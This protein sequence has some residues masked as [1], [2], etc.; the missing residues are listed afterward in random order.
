MVLWRLLRV[1]WANVLRN[2]R[3]FLF[4]SVGLV[5]G[6]GTFTFFV[7]LGAGIKD[8]VLN[9]IYP[10]N[11][12]EVEPA[13]VGLLGLREE[14]VDTA[15]FGPGTVRTFEAL[16][17]V[18]AVYPKLRS[19]LQAR[20]WGGRSIF[21]YDARTEAFFDGLDPALVTSELQAVERV[22]AKRERS[23]MRRP[24]PCLRDDECPLG[25][26]CGPSGA[27]RRVEYWRRFAAPDMAV[28]CAREGDGR[29]CLAGETCLGGLCR[30]PCEGGCPTGE[31]CA[32]VP[33]CA[34]DGCR[35]CAPVCAADGDC[36]STRSCVTGS[37]G[38]RSCQRLA[39]TLERPEAQFSH[40]SRDGRGRVLGR[41]AN[42]VP[43]GD[44]ACEP[45]SCPPGTYCAPHSIK[46][47]EG[48]CERPLPVVLSPFLIEV[49]NTAV[50][51]SLGLQPID[52]TDALL[53]VQF[54]IQLGNSFFADDLPEDQQIVR[55]TEITGFS[56]KALDFGATFPLDVVRR[57]NA[58]YKGTAAAERYDTFIIETAGNE[59]VS[60]L[61]ADL[62]GRGFALSRKSQDARKAADVLFILTVVFS[63]ISLVIM[64]VAAV[65]ITHTFLMIVTERRHEIGIMRAVGASRA[66]I[67]RIVLAEAALL[68][69]FGGA[70]GEL[71]GFAAS[72]GVNLAAR[73]FLGQV[74]FKPDDFFVYEASTLASG[75]LFALVFCL[76]GASIPARRAARL[77][78][79]VVLTS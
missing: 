42:G 44:P 39:C 9:R 54:R 6:V 43:P 12:I 53:G 32:A 60:A 15:S 14:V 11:Q 78:P 25:Q 19:K 62:E 64:A 55:R 40:R 79:A 13:T 68:G 16:G 31:I 4:S 41:C 2:K 75:V 67:R 1:V 3:S 58:R 45:S 57:I 37:D 52:G 8:G 29:R 5:V 73:A 7:A 70:V 20:L 74:P 46:S 47:A 51:S 18:V 50:A 71:L 63:F 76:L 26:E 35:A 65:N 56:S 38:A 36:G 69:V 72:R 48:T 24:V 28:G 66:D 23:A 10:V 27:C 22:A 17:D 34:T 59:D 30:V 49:F 33:G 21:G 77:D 61:V